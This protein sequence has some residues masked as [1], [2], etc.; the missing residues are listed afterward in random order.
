L[1]RTEVWKT[2]IMELILEVSLAM[3]P[4]S[5][6]YTDISTE[7]GEAEGYG[8]SLEEDGED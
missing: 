6:L 4:C 8:A 7:G 3:R 1:E 2:L 5:R